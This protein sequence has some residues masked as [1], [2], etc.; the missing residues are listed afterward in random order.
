MVIR[1]KILQWAIRSLPPKFVNDKNMV[2]LQRLNG[3]G[4]VVILSITMTGLRYS[5]AYRE[6]YRRRS[7]FYAFEAEY[8]PPIKYK[9]L[10]DLIQNY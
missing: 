6:T 9:I 7:G 3:Y 10:N 5:L 8:T 1:I 2:G 4:L